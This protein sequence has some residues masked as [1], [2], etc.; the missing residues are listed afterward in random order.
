MKITKTQLKQIIKEELE[1]ES[2]E[3]KSYYHESLTPEEKRVEDLCNELAKAVYEMGESN[4]DL[5]DTYLRV[6]RAL[7]GAGLSLQAMAII[8]VGII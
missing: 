2:E 4:P 1:R 7:K 6:F 5:T 3:G 8:G